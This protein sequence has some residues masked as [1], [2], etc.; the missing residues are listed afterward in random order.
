MVPTANYPVVDRGVSGAGGP[1]EF[2]GRANTHNYWGP[3]TI[4]PVGRDGVAELS[5][6]L[7][8]NV[9]NTPLD[10]NPYK[11]MQIQVTW[12]PVLP[13]ERPNLHADSPGF[14]SVL[15][16]DWV[17][18]ETVLSDG[19]IHTTY[20]GTGFGDLTSPNPFHNPIGESFQLT[21][22][23]YVDQVVIDTACIPEP[24]LATLGVFL[25]FT[26]YGFRRFVQRL[27]R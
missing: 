7:L 12:K 11:E 8:F 15:D 16:G 18:T 25:G 17:K 26:G 9:P 24:S 20:F 4:S 19:W 27:R 6:D 14:A 2:T 10:H 23:I 1:L 3:G 13:G 21:G 22:N 5:G